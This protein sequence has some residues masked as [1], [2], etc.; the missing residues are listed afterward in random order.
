[1]CHTICHS[2]TEALDDPNIRRSYDGLN[3]ARSS[4]GALSSV[5]WGGSEKQGG[6]AHDSDNPFPR[7]EHSR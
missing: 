1:M 4:P 6:R 5:A 3:S 2:T 7:S